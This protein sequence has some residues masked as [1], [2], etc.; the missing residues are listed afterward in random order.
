M[1][2]NIQKLIG[3]WT[4]GYALV[5]HTV[6][7]TPIREVKKTVKILVDG[8]EKEIQ[9]HGDIIG[10]DNKY[11]ELGEHLNKLKYHKERN[12]ITP[13]AQEAA[14]FLNGKSEWK[15]DLIIPVPP[16]EAGRFSQPVEEL[17]NAIGRI[18]NIAVDSKTLKKLKSTAPLKGIT[19]P[20]S[21]KEILK[22]AFDIPSN[23]LSEKN[24]LIFDDLYRSG[25]TLNAVCG[26]T[27][28]KGNAKNIFVL[29]ITKTRTKR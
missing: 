7:S 27:K 26:I 1:E 3:H 8:K 28:N 5:L 11:S 29:T 13:I 16:S 4:E 15:I 18:S 20:D 17:A 23:F 12:R 6:S 19:D 9:L 21:R 25:E 10:W 24:V 14:A 2:I 22:D